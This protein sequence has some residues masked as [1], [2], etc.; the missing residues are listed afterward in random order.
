MGQEGKRRKGVS[1]VKTEKEEAACTRTGCTGQ[2]GRGSR[3]EGAR[4]AR[5]ESEAV[6]KRISGKVGK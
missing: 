3:A 6:G 2:A 1:V 4:T 5:M